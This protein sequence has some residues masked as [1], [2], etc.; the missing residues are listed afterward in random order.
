MLVCQNDPGRRDAL[1][2]DVADG[3]LLLAVNACAEVV[4]NTTAHLQV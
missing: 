1:F 3:S 2:S 4:V